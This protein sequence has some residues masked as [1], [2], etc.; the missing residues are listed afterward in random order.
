M[1]PE[2][3]AKGLASPSLHTPAES[4]HRPAKAYDAPERRILKTKAFPQR[5][6]MIFEKDE[7]SLQQER[8]KRSIVFQGSMTKHR[9]TPM[10]SSRDPKRHKELPILGPERAP[11][12][13][14]HV[15]DKPNPRC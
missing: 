7:D 10:Y 3:M 15:P 11:P 14:Q 2:T 12:Q 9:R 13:L 8:L 1:Y 5:Y 4:Q 6:N